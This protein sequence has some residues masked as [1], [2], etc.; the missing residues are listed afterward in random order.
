MKKILLKMIVLAMIGAMIVV[1]VSAQSSEIMPLWDN[2]STVDVD[3]TFS[4]NSGN[5]SGCV[6]RQSGV[7]RMEGTITLYEYVGNQWVYVNEW[8][9]STTRMALTISGDFIAVSCRQYQAV[10][11]VTAYRNDGTL[12]ET[13][14][15]EI[16]RTCP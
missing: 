11:T 5:V 2:V 1:P 8:Y 9:K 6:T 16:I 3:M 14:T 12:E 10:M 13:V 4:G 7:V 15:D